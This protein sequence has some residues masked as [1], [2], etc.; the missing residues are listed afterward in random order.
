MFFYL[1]SHHFKT[2]FCVTLPYHHFKTPFCVTLQYHH[3]KTPFC[4]TL[5]YHHFK[6]PFCVTLQY[7]HFKTP[8][9]VALQYHHFKTPFCVTLQYHQS[10]RETLCQKERKYSVKLYV[11]FF[12][13]YV[14]FLCRMDIYFK[15][16][17]ISQ[18]GITMKHL[19]CYSS[20]QSSLKLILSVFK[21]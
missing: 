20:I 9:C 15:S 10:K 4:V 21:K 1:I 13:F 11:F 17:M 19:T 12:V 16:L 8:F 6:T 3:F 14:G 5:Q 2:P 18:G 7:H